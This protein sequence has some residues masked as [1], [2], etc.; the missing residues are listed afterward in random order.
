[1]NIN[2][3]PSIEQMTSQIGG[4]NNNTSI[5]QPNQ[6]QLDKNGMSFDEILKSQ[7]NSVDNNIVFSKHANE[8]LESRNIELSDVQMER[9]NEATKL[10]ASKGIKESLVMLDDY[11]FI[12][13]TK[14]N[15]VVTAIGK[16]EKNVFTNI[17]GAVI[18]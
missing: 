3:F 5:T 6:V 15:M 16:Q 10:A 17:D 13:N 4:V 7:Q 9:L 18:A 1:M 14:N 8:R 11:N 2:Q 12:V